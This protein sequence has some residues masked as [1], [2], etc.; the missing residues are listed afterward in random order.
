[1][2][3]VLIVDDEV[4]IREG[5]KILLSAYEDLNI[6]GLCG[7]GEE[8]YHFCQ[9]NQDVDIVLMDIRMEKCD[10]VIATKLIKSLDYEIK[11]LILTTFKDI[12]YITS[13]LSYGANGYILK[14]SSSDKIYEALKSTYLGN[15]VVHPDVLGNMMRNQKE[16][17]SNDRIIKEYGLTA[18]EIEIVKL[19]AEGM[20]NKEISVVLYLA[21]GTVKNNI[22][23]I[24]SKLHLRDRTQIAIFAFKNLLVE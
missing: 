1:M 19:V 13:A 12:A 3:N 5:L 17:F 22:S 14:D 23:T 11:I 10:G 4:L 21:E 24:L 2:I 16:K 9:K 6:I 15:V 7:D 20:T 8:A 18:K